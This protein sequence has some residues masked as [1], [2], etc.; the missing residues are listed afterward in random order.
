MPCVIPHSRHEAHRRDRF[1]DERVTAGAHSGGA[2]RMRRGCGNERGIARRWIGPQ[3][4]RELLAVDGR[5]H[6]VEEQD[7][8]ARRLREREGVEPRRRCVNRE[9]KVFEDETDGIAQLLVVVGHEDAARQPPPRL[10]AGALRRPRARHE[11]VS[12]LA[13]PRAPWRAAV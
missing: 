3:H 8:R 6:H 1:S 11:N 13:A 4:L 7:A 10:R 9:A 2:Q 5:Q 12:V